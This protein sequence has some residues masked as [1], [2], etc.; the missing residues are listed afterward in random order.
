MIKKQIDKIMD[1]QKILRGMH[2]PLKL[3]PAFMREKLHDLGDCVWMTK[4][5]IFEES[6]RYNLGLKDQFDWNKLFGWCYG[7]TGIHRNSV[8][9]VWRY[10][11]MS[12]KIEVG[13]Y[14]Y[15]DGLRLY[16]LRTYRLDIG[17]KYHITLENNC[18]TIMLK[19]D[20]YPA[21]KRLVAFPTAKKAYA[22]GL[23]F[24]GSRRAPHTMTISMNDDLSF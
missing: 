16:P 17:M 13:L 1:N 7:I 15:V 9:V 24:G 18:D 19:V 12:D 22:C 14:M 4:D 6:C 11:D 20:G 5:V 8:R 21:E 10:D 23:Y 3:M 2:R